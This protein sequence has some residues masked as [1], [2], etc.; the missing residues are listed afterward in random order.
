MHQG[1][2]LRGTMDGLALGISESVRR[3]QTEDNIEYRTQQDLLFF[4]PIRLRSNRRASSFSPTQCHCDI[5]QGVQSQN[6]AVV[7]LTA[8]VRSFGLEHI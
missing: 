2:I 8:Y 4:V 5:F 3:Q 6:P 7:L 1:T